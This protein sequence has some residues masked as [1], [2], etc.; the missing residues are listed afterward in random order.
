M[1]KRKLLNI[2][3]M[4][5]APAILAALLFLTA[6]LFSDNMGTVSA[7]NTTSSSVLKL[8]DGAGAVKDLNTGRLLDSDYTTY[9]YVASGDTLTITQESGIASL[10]IIWNKVPGEWTLSANGIDY[11]LGQNGFLHEYIDIKSLTGTS[12]TEISVKVHGDI[13]ICDIYTFTEG[14]L[15]EWVQTWNAP[16][17]KADIMLLSTH[18]DDE[19]L[20]FAGLLPY[21]AGEIGASV[22]VVYLTNHWDV[23]NRPHEQ[24]NG[25]WAVGVRN[26][27]VVGPFPDDP[28]TLNRTGELP[29]E[30]LARVLEIFGEDALCQFQVEMIRRF[31]PQVIVGHDVNGEYQHGA[32]IANTYS[33]K[34]ALEIASDEAK[35]PESA[36]LYGT[37]SPL[38]TYIHLLK[39]NEIVMNWDVPL[40]AFGGKTAFEVSKEGYARHYSQHWTWF[41]RWL[42]GTDDGYEDTILLASQISTYSPCEYGLYSTSVGQDTGADM[43]EHITLYRDQAAHSPVPSETEE[44]SV[45]P[46]S[47]DISS[48]AET[49]K[50]S[51][52]DTEHKTDDR[53]N[54]TDSTNRFRIY[55]VV[56]IFVL[57]AAI[58]AVRSIYC[59]KKH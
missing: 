31:K 24:I 11:N 44:P 30:T 10:Y 54:L 47:P 36:E 32:H 52:T 8:N 48:P 53:N 6:F 9:V 13:S 21:Y 49:P 23:Q 51:G 34:E 39:E 43:L 37:W 46:A 1:H 35:Y 42:T 58:T 56:A 16:C 4:S 19:H 5:I 3:L 12:P 15:P 27:P 2:S 57:L 28:D 20:F 25:L 14:T 22:Q 26:Y 33:L 38:K 45:S 18:S 55:C 7:D 41:T 29:E 50:V 40:E 59:A 17:E